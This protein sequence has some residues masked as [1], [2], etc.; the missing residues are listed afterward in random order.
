L[1]YGKRIIA[2]ASIAV[3]RP[4]EIA[5]RPIER[6]GGATGYFA[7]DFLWR[8]RGMLDGFLGGPGLARG[9]PPRET[10]RVGDKVDYWHVAELVPGRRL[11]L[12]CEMKL[13]G[14]G[15]LEFEVTGDASG[16]V[17]RQTTA[18]DPR[19]IGGLVY[20][21]GMYPLHQMV[22]DAMLRAIAAAAMREPAI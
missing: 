12:D 1:T 8:S 10:L 11:R 15:W 6:I 9:R 20:W 18:F 19:G 13:P 16:S 21:Y 7:F 22:F 17:I 5:F 4:P 14:R 3:A 2:T